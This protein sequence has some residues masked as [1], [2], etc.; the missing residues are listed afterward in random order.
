MLVVLPFVAFLL[1]L[2]IWSNT[3][4]WQRSAL[5]AATSWA[6]FSVVTTEIL[7]LGQW[8]NTSGLSLAW[9]ALNFVLVAC[10]LYYFQSKRVPTDPTMQAA[11]GGDFKNINTVLVVGILLVVL[12][13]GVG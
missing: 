10:W 13:T 5:L 8:L 12:L 4:C 3:F 9:L 7:S 1:F 2:L 11:S 6:I